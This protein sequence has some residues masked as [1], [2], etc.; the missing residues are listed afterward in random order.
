MRLAAVIVNPSRVREL[1]RL[2]QQCHRTAAAY[3]WSLPRVALTSEADGGAGMTRSAIEAGAE[4]VICVGGDGT[5]RECAQS[6]AGTDVPLAIVPAGSAN[7]TARAVGVPAALDAAL[8]T[9]FGGRDARVDLATA[10]GA[11]FTAMAGIGLDAAV[12]AATPDGAKRLAGWPAY[13]GAAVSQLLRRP[14]TFVLR[15]DGGDPITRRAR[16]VT[17]GNSGALPGGFVIMPDARIDDGVLDVLILA[18]SGVAGWVEVG[19]RVAVHSRRDG[20]Q[21][22]RHRARTVEISADSDLPRQID[23]EIVTSARSL[24]VAVRPGALLVRVPL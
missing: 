9:G 11:V 6:L 23:G 5:V 19:L 7:L 20:R 22:E 4:L 15:L 10:D 14:A 13:A 1:D 8:A 2:R 17:V 16:S 24:T 12:V 3:G 18:P 21:L